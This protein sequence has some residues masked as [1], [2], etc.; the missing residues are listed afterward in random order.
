VH[1]GLGVGLILGGCALLLLVAFGLRSRAPAA[2]SMSLGA[3][4][5][6]ALAAGALL[7]QPHASSADW[8]VAVGAMA[9]LA[10]AHIRVV[11][12]PFRSLKNPPM[13][14]EDARGA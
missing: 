14:A 1:T 9:F 2:A 5:G 12:G 7:V 3:A 11:L 13:L 4:G 6:G 8:V 10:P